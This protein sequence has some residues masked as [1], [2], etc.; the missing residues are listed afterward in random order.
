MT[1]LAIETKSQILSSVVFD[2]YRTF[3]RFLQNFVERTMA[4]ARADQ[5]LMLKG[6]T[7]YQIKEIIDDLDIDG[8]FA[9][10]IEG[11]RVKIRAS[12]EE[13]RQ[14]RREYRR[15]YRQRPG[16][17]K[18]LRERNDDPDIQNKRRKYSLREDVKQAK[19]RTAK[20]RR[21]SLR[22]I[23]DELPSLFEEYRGK[24]LQKLVAAES[25]SRDEENKATTEV[26]DSKKEEKEEK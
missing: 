2:I 10:M 3:Y 25:C 8:V 16:V 13:R 20:T 15:E 7:S 19:R 22:L 12:C 17:R 21:L 26:D 14:K 11:S 5:M 9:T 18:R 24:A 6:V 4:V 23:Q 1:K